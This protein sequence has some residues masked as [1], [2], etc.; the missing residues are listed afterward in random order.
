MGDSSGDASPGGGLDSGDCSGDL[1]D[2]HLG[3]HRQGDELIGTS[4]RDRKVTPL[5][6]QHPAGALEMNRNGIVKAKADLPP[7]QRLAERL[8]FPDSDRVGVVDVLASGPLMRRGNSV[9]PFESSVIGLRMSPTL[10]IL[11]VQ[12]SKLEA[13][14]SSLDSIHPAVPTE[15]G[16]PV[17]GR[18]SVIS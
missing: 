15:T 2:C 6:T 3:K 12:R 1:C 16:M 9:K 4:F 18:L 7:I 8:S 13:Q 11:V 10:L 14:Y 17:L 5:M